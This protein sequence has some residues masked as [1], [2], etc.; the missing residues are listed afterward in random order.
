MNPV[1]RKLEERIPIRVRGLVHE[2]IWHRMS[3]A[4]R[5][6]VKI[7]SGFYRMIHPRGRISPAVIVR[8]NR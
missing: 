7:E 8:V 1:Y 6:T 2:R 5:Y 4:V 3:G